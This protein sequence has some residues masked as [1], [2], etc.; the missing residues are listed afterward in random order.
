MEEDGV[1]SFEL[2]IFI[3]KFISLRL[4]ISLYL[5][6][7]WGKARELALPLSFINF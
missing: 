4:R 7:Q 2:D 3:Q 6:S 5:H 1:E